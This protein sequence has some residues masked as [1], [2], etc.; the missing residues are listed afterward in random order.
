[1]HLIV[2]MLTCTF[3]AEKLTAAI[4][5]LAPTFMCTATHVYMHEHLIVHMCKFLFLCTPERY[6]QLQSRPWLLHL[7]YNIPH[8]SLLWSKC[9]VPFLTADLIPDLIPDLT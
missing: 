9:D 7:K 6:L 3:T 5:L 8:P 4:L 1:M 2:H